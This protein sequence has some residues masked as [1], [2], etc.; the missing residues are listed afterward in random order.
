MHDPLEAVL[1][2]AA[3]Q[4]VRPGFDVI[5]PLPGLGIEVL[6]ACI[7]GFIRLGQFIGALRER[8]IQQQSELCQGFL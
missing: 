7:Q 8:R 6:D 4:D 5:E 3:T 2:L 1:T